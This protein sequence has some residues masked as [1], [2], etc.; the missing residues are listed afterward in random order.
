[1]STVIRFAL[2]SLIV[3]MAL[4]APPGPAQ[5]QMGI[6]NGGGGGGNGGRVEVHNQSDAWTWITVYGENFSDAHHFGAKLLIFKTE[7]VG[8]HSTK[9]FRVTSGYVREVRGEATQR[10]CAHPVMLDRTLGWDGKTPYYLTGSK[11]KYK[12][13][14]T[15]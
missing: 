13:W 4:V 1:M 3:T 7:C 10:N 6:P 5:A 14:H 11:G 8:P 12:F 2:V 15:P 9:D